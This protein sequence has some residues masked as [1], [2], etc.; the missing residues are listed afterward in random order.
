MPISMDAVAA[1]PLSSVLPEIKSEIKAEDFCE[2]QTLGGT[3]VDPSNDTAN[4]GSEVQTMTGGQQQQS[5]VQS[6]Q[7][8]QTSMPQQTQLSELQNAQQQNA[9]CSWVGRRA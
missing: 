9:N 7:Q 6:S 5:Q 1:Q 8:Q 3:A 4:G 2:P